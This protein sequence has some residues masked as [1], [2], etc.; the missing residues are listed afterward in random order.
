MIDEQEGF[1]EASKQ[2]RIQKINSK[3]RINE[4]EKTYIID[5]NFDSINYL[6]HIHKRKF[7][8]DNWIDN[9]VDIFNEVK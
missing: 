2:Q 1:E 3:T 9:I 6:F 8:L 5:I 7:V 4:E